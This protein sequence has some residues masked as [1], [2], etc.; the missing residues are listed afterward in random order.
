MRTFSDDLENRLLHRYR[1]SCCRRQWDRRRR[2]DG[3]S[4]LQALVVKTRSMILVGEAPD[5]YALIG[6]RK[7][8]RRVARN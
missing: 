3:G 6:V 1:A 5:G 4:P 8:R 2:A 7:T